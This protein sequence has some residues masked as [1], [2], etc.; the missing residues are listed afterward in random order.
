MLIQTLRDGVLFLTIDRANSANAL[1]RALF[2]A[3]HEA[4]VDAHG[5]AHVK[6]IVLGSVGTKVFSAGADLKELA[7]QGHAADSDMS[8]HALLTRALLDIL[9][10]FI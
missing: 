6:A 8:V 1:N 5:N 7:N 3:L 2:E 9:D 10:L 4:F